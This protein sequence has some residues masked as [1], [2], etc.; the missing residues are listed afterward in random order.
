MCYLNLCL[1]STEVVTLGQ[2]PMVFQGTLGN[3]QSKDLKNCLR[4]SSE[5]KSSEDSFWGP[6]TGHSPGSRGKLWDL[7]IIPWLCRFTTFYYWFPM[8]PNSENVGHWE[9]CFSMS[10]TFCEKRGTLVV[11]FFNVPHFLPQCPTFY[12]ITLGNVPSSS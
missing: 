3:V 8:S 6:R 2:G 10:P 9:D 12:E 11:L 1:M 7:F 4:N 5:A